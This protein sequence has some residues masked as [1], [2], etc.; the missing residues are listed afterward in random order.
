MRGIS[1]KTTDDYLAALPMEF[2]AT[3]ETLRARIMAIAPEANE[4]F[5]YGMPAYKYHG[6]PLVYMGAAK[7]HCALYGLVTT[8]YAKELAAYDISK[9]VIRF[10]PG[11]APPVTLLRKLLRARMREID[12]ANAERARSSRR[13]SA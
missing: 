8:P 4:G 1:A 3:L 2:R 13:R 12:Q 5:A 11:K 7:R 9:G 6:R 10:P